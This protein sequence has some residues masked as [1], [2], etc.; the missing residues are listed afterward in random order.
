M[1][2]YMKLF[3]VKWDVGGY[4]KFLNSKED[5]IILLCLSEKP[6]CF[7]CKK[8]I[9]KYPFFGRII[10]SIDA[11]FIDRHNIMNQLDTIRQTVKQ[12]K[13]EEFG[14]VVIYIEGTRNKELHK[15]VLEYKAGTVK[16]AYMSGIPILPIVTYGCFRILSIKYHLLSYPCYVRFLDPIPKEEYKDVNSVE[17]AAKIEKMTNEE[18]DRLRLLDI[19][20][21]KGSKN[22]PCDRERALTISYKKPIKQFLIMFS[23]SFGVVVLN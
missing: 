9:Q 18:I 8:E 16:T 3:R 14:N 5:A 10:S 21:L 12:A 4:Q 19:S 15:D 6:L 1:T 11:I 13:G 2:F 7:V 17:M 20:V 22:L 23:N